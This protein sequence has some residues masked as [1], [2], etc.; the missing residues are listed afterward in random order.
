[1]KLS[2]VFWGAGV[3]AGSAVSAF[4]VVPRSV[5]PSFRAGCS[6]CA[7][8]A[9]VVNI[10]ERSGRDVGALDEWASACGVQRVEGFQL[11]SEDGGIDW[12]VVTTQPLA[13]GSPVLFVPNELILSSN[14]VRQE[15]GNAVEAAVDQLQR[16]GAIDQIPQFYLFIKILTMYEMGDQS[17]WFPWLNSLPR[18]YFNAVSMT[19]KSKNSWT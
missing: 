10:D 15:L 7:P 4:Q 18:L 6:S 9:A 3:L 1:M 11:N 12:S 13:E 5:L 14:R 17:P 8:L 2:V 19:S 16:L